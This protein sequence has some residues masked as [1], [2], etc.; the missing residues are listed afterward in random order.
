MAPSRYASHAAHSLTYSLTHSLTQS[1]THSPTHSLAHSPTSGKCKCEEGRCA[2]L[3]MLL[4]EGHGR[5]GPPAALDLG[6]AKV[7]RH[8]S[9]T[10][11][12]HRASVSGQWAS[13]RNCIAC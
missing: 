9:S 4:D 8:V 1:I 7:S 12:V 11:A 2:V 3:N 13:W 5:P 6:N 10:S